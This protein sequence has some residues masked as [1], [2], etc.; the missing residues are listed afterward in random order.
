VQINRPKTVCGLLLALTGSIGTTN[1]E[2]SPTEILMKATTLTC[3]FTS[4]Q[5]TRWGASGSLKE[6][7]TVL[8]EAIFDSI[9]HQTG[10]GK[11]RFSKH[12]VWQDDQPSRSVRIRVFTHSI[13]FFELTDD[14]ALDPIITTV[15]DDYYADTTKFIA[16]RS[17]HWTSAFRRAIASQETG[18]CVP[19]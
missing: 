5:H 12:F 7:G 15:L 11:R 1:A 17:A 3:I 4:E 8:N 2:Q 14:G 9:N 19:G 16:V 6:E 10:Q 13:T 18:T